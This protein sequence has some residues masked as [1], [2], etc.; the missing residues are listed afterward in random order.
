MS[1]D[2]L[3]WDYEIKSGWTVYKYP[4]EK[5]LTL[6]QIFDDRDWPRDNNGV[7]LYH[8]PLKKDEA[9]EGVRVIYKGNIFDYVW[10][11]DKITET[12]DGFIIDMGNF[13]SYMDWDEKEKEWVTYG[14][15]AKWF[16]TDEK[17]EGYGSII[18]P[19]SRD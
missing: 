2:E 16:D 12:P 18:I 10:N 19:A 11:E 4:E 8:I 9:K 17:I 7:P 1:K 14:I 5:H 13:V 3:A 6:S 15:I